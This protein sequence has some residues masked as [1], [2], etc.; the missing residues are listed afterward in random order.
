MQIKILRLQ[1]PT[2]HFDKSLISFFILEGSKNLQIVQIQDDQ[3]VF[4]IELLNKDS[5]PILE[6]FKKIFPN[7]QISVILEKY[8][9]VE[10]WKR[11]RLSQISVGK[12]NFKPFF[13]K[14]P[15]DPLE[16]IYL[17]TLVGAFGI[18]NHP[19]TLICLELI[20]QLEKTIH[21]A[22]YITA[23]DFGTGNGI[24]S[25]ALSRSIKCII[26]IEIIYTYC[27]ECLHN[28]KI[29]NIHNIT[30]INSDTPK[31]VRKTDVLVANIPL[32]VYQ[33]VPVLEIKFK[34][35]I[36]SGVNLQNYTQLLALFE[37]NSIEVEKEIEKEGWKGFLVRKKKV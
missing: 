19:T 35:A 18:D 26:A 30:V 4:Q 33:Q 8:I 23:V 3:L 13:A 37:N 14:S 24:L 25:L 9:S 32:S 31:I 36:I 2:Q 15:D 28:T 1:T 22:N 12:H 27:L 29:N 34:Q 6:K 16:T 7:K 5:Q 17:D 21:E 11:I 10:E 20:D